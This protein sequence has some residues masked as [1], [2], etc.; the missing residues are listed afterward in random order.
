MKPAG[1][2]QDRVNFYRNPGRDTDRQADPTWPNTAG[3]SIPCAIM[4]GSGGGEL[5]KGNSLAARE[6][7][8]AVV[9]GGSLGCVV[10]VV[11]SLYLY[12]C[13]HCSLCLLF[14]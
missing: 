13:C 9:E 14:C 2:G 5:G 1:F 4:L 8:T 12:R 3:Y 11:F 7:A 10:C 6:L